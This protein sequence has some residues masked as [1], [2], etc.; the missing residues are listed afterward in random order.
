MDK[1]AV[2]VHHPV[3]S[4]P[5][6]Y[7][8]APIDFG[9]NDSA[10]ARFRRQLRNP[11]LLTFVVLTLAALAVPVLIL[12]PGFYSGAREN[13]RYFTTEFTVNIF[14]LQVAVPSNIV[15][16]LRQR[17]EIMRNAA[18]PSE[19]NGVSFESGPCNLDNLTELPEGKYA[20]AVAVAC[21]RIYTV[22]TTYGASCATASSCA[23][24]VAA[25]AE[26]DEIEAELLLEFS[27]AYSYLA[28]EETSEP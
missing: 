5:K 26:L 11:S 17:M 12:L 2:R 4:S 20:D 24:P 25:V 23:V 13:I 18:G 15:P 1:R 14:E 22:Q 9:D 28:E 8:I 7:R 16:Y 3:S 19:W 21:Q 10:F 27:D 6:P